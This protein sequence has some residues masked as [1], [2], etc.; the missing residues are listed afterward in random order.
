MMVEFWKEKSMGRKQN[1]NKIKETCYMCNMPATSREHVPP[2]CFFP[3]QKDFGRSKD[4][5]QNL[6][7]VSSCDQHNTSKSQDD[8]Y[9]LFLIT[10]HFDNNLIAQKHFSTKIIRAV[11]RNPSMYKFVEKNSPILIDGQPTIAYTVDLARFNKEIDHITRALFYIHYNQ[12]L[13]LP[14]N[15]H[16]P[17]LFA[18]NQQDAD[19]IN[20]HTKEI[21][22]VTV[23]ALTTQPK[24]GQNKEVF[25]YQHMTIP[26]I[27]SFVFRMVFYS[28]FVVIAYA[29]STIG[30]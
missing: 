17:D 12:K 11:K 8:E 21:E 1:P 27:P 2:K 10:S 29:S 5:R 22:E 16:T 6:L 4:Y 25:Y 26:H 13:D 14:I 23:N 24:H 28:G 3:E 9:L 20:Q 19:K 30:N 7:S 15:I 18:I